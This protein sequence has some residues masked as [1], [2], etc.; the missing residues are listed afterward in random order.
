MGLSHRTSGPGLALRAWDR[1]AS[2]ELGLFIVALIVNRAFR[3]GLDINDRKF[4]PYSRKRIYIG[5]NSE[6]ARR[7]ASEP[8]WRS[9]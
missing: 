6:T 4:K 3:K 7:R 9:K 1:R 2:R 8:F 5:K